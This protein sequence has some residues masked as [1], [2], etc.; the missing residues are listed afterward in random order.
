MRAIIVD[1]EQLVRR[2][3]SEK[4]AWEKLG[5]SLAGVCRNGLEAIELIRSERIEIVITDV[6]MPELDGI[7]LIDAAQK[8]DPPP[9]FVVISGYSEFEFARKAMAYGVRHYVLKPT[10]IEELERAI[11]E[12]M[13]EVRGDR[14]VRA[15]INSSPSS[16]RMLRDASLASVLQGRCESGDE[17]L[18]ACGRLE[19]DPDTP[20]LA[21]IVVD[22]GVKATPAGANRAS[23]LIERVLEGIVPVGCIAEEQLAIVLSRVVSGLDVRDAIDPLRDALAR[24]S[25][26][27][28]TIL[29]AG[30]DRC[31]RLPAELERIRRCRRDLFYARLDDVIPASEASVDY[32]DE[33]PERLERSL[34]E[35]K[36]LLRSG[37]AENRDSTIAALGK[38][39]R[40]ALVRPKLFKHAVLEAVREVVDAIGAD[41][42]N[43][44]METVSERI[45][46][47]ERLDELES[48]LRALSVELAPSTGPIYYSQRERTVAAVRA[49]M[50]RRY[51]EQG[52]SLRKIAATEVFANEDYLSRIF[53]ESTGRRFTEELRQLRMEEAVRLMEAFPNLSVQEVSSRVGYGENAQYFSREFHRYYGRTPTQWKLEHQTAP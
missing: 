13:D 38:E 48:R 3:L 35:L 47:A 5:L 19:I 43:C 9:G 52:L 26:P 8:L 23:V 14:E 36:N 50:R 49:A 4:V 22:L 2:G 11:S 6:L 33:I 29:F 44:R 42:L 40:Y 37:D 27:R 17:L 24:L 31:D 18:A 41:R 30:P 21:L 12:T 28:R 32:T 16:E 15:R 51:V 46:S 7:G 25:T 20:D 39:T 10:R 45:M 34:G 53:R 1:D